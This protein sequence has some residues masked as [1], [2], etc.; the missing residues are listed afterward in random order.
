[1]KHTLIGIAASIALLSGSS[2]SAQAIEGFVTGG[3]HTDTNRQQF[4]GLGGGVLTGVKWIGVGV[5]G[6][7][8]FSLPYVG[9]RFTMLV[10]GNVFDLAGV[11]PF[12]QVGKGYGEFRGRMYGAGVDFRPR[13]AR[14]GVRAS[15]Q[16]YLA[17]MWSGE[18]RVQPSV[19]VGVIWTA[20]RNTAEP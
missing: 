1:M 2:A 17:E 9:G 8:F 4:T 13:N 18:K 14:V 11:R 6:D 7:A 12:V 5:Q 15:Y 20:S 16:A 19:T 10:Q 3:A